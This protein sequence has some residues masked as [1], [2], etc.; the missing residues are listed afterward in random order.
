MATEMGQVQGHD[1]TATNRLTSA[2]VAGQGETDAYRSGEANDRGHAP[3]TQP[4]GGGTARAHEMGSGRPR[5]GDPVARFARTFDPYAG[6]GNHL[7]MGTV[8]IGAIATAPHGA[9]THLLQEW[10]RRSGRV[11]PRTG[12]R[13]AVGRPR[14]AGVEGRPIVTAA[15]GDTRDRISLYGKRKVVSPDDNGEVKT[16]RRDDRARAC[17]AR[18]TPCR[19]L[20]FGR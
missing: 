12:E 15:G 19:S 5:P 2:L 14:T 9:L 16:P 13:V 6:S 20:T 7:A 11:V 3:R 8:P 1:G 18:E 10:A 17:E 4:R